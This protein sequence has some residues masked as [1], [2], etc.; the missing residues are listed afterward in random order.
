MHKTTLFSLLILLSSSTFYASSWKFVETSQRSSRANSEASVDDLSEDNTDNSELI[1]ISALTD[2]QREASP[3]VPA[4][5][6]S[7]S[8]TNESSIKRIPRYLDDIEN[9]N[10]EISKEAQEKALALLEKAGVIK[11][12]P[13]LS[14]GTRLVGNFLLLTGSVALF[15]YSATRTTYNWGYA[16]FLGDNLPQFFGSTLKELRTVVMATSGFMGLAAL[17]ELCEEKRPITYQLQLQKK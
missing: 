13:E 9:D 5:K 12:E 6:N 14:G 15:A 7:S 8:Q 2:A 17:K 4:Y 10:K 11:K 16:S 3:D 1:R